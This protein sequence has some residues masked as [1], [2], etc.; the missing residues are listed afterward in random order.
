MHII[1]LENEVTS[2]RG[3]QELSLFDVCLGLYKRGHTITL[4]YVTEGNLLKEYHFF[5]NELI[6]ING[7]RIERKK[8]LIHYTSFL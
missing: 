7:F 8:Y 3:G 5:C 1:V 6:K 2:L 4:V